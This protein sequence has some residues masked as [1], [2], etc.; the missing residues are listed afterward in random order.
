M[1]SGWLPLL[2]LS[3]GSTSLTTGCGWFDDNCAGKALVAS[4]TPPLSGAALAAWTQTTCTTEED[5]ICQ[6]GIPRNNSLMLCSHDRSVAVTDAGAYQALQCQFYSD[7]KSCH[8]SSIESHA[9]PNLPVP[10]P[11]G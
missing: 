7:A 4:T 3:L 8:S 2:V 6:L 9:P 1:R 5:D 11:P 10:P